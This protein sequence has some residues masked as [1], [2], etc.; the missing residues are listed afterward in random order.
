MRPSTRSPPRHCKA[1]TP[2]AEGDEG[3]GGGEAGLAERWRR[4]ETPLFSPV[5][6]SRTHRHLST[7]DSAPGPIFVSQSATDFRPPPFQRHAFRRKHARNKQS[8][9]FY[10]K[11]VVSKNLQDKC[12]EGLKDFR[13]IHQ[14]HSQILYG[15]L[16]QMSL[17]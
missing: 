14:H 2:R 1:G 9:S 7:K 15:T 17:G 16:L 6:L 5:A 11:L 10:N 4:Q 12:S 13:P 3:E 8:V